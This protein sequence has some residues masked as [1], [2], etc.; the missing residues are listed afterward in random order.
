MKLIIIG[1]DHR[2]QSGVTQDP[3]TKAWIPRDGKRFRRLIT[4]CTEELGA[5]AILE[6][7]HPKQEQVA[8][9]ICS[10]IAKER[11]IAWKPLALGEPDLPDV[12]LDPPIA[13]AMRS[14]TKPVLLAGRYG[15]QTHK[16][17]ETFM[18]ATI[19]QALQDHCC[20]LAVVGYIHL[21][22]LARRF[23]DSRIGS[24]EALLFTP[25]LV[26]ENLA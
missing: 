2:L 21:G 18:F 11:G 26:D 8:P 7:V 14:G 6:E 19:M 1:T 16:M 12:L 17:R 22:L 25:L 9:S 4:Y 23:E 13:V 20:V 5:K 15:L 10:T 3:E 24:V